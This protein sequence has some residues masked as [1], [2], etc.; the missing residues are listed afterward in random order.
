MTAK[1]V[2]QAGGQ[3]R[4][5]L[6][7]TGT[8]NIASVCASLRRIGCE[9]VVTDDAR[10]VEDCVALVVPGVGT[11]GAAL[12]TLRTSGVEAALAAR[13]AAGRAT[14]GI[15]VGLQILARSSC[16]SP[17]VAGLGILPIEVER[18]PKGLRVPQM[19]WNRIVS[20]ASARLVRDG[21]VYFANSYHIPGARAEALR[22]AGWSLAMAEHGGPFVAAVERGPVL[23]C[24][25][26]LELSGDFGAELAT[27]WLENC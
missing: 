15:C 13:I 4:V 23:A 24:Q 5:H 17:G 12:A 6:L 18:F 19:G 21:F 14:L 7:A 8:A 20:D 26:H 2:S 1:S 16:E 11:F 22:G 27:R 9:P 25:F 10:E 3:R